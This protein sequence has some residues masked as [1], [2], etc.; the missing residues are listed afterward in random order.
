MKN[1]KINYYCDES[2]Y[3]YEKGLCDGGVLLNG[4]VVKEI[5]GYYRDEYGDENFDI[6]YAKYVEELIR[7]KLE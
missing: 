6:M 3:Y 4:K 5:I 7:K 2:K 1:L